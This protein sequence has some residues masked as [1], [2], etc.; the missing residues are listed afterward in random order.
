MILNGF[1]SDFLKT[2]DNDAPDVCFC[3]KYRMNSVSTN[4]R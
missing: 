4:L 3:K 2:F 1:D